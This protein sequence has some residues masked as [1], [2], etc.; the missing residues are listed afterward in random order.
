M[1]HK[2]QIGDIANV[3][4]S[5]VD[6]K[7]VPGQRK[8]KLC[9]YMDAYNNR[10]I[11]GEL[12]FMIATAKADQI[13]KYRLLPDDVIITK[14]SETPEDIAIPTVVTENIDDLICG[15]HLAILRPKKSVNGKF[16]MYRL[17]EDAVRRQ[18]FRVANGSTRYGLTIGAIENVNLDFPEESEQNC[19]VEILEATQEVI[20][21]TQAMMDK[22][23]K[24]KA[25]LLQDLLTRGVDANGKLRNEKQSLNGTLSDVVNLVN[26]KIAIGKNP[27]L[28]YIGLEHLDKRTLHISRHGNALD[29]VSTNNVFSPND[30]LFGKL[31]P[32]LK[33]C[34]LAETHGYCSTDILVLRANTNI[35]PLFSLYI[36]SSEPIFYEAIKSTEG[37]K[38]PRTSWAAIKDVLVYLPDTEEQNLI[39]AV[40]DSHLQKK[41]DTENEL[42]KLKKLKAG[43]MQDLLTGKKRISKNQKEAE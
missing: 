17:C 10:Y 15:Y 8:I 30:I 20:A 13:E 29:S 4:P 22:Q 34:A 25:G 43:L 32:N 1:W 21:A 16:L 28:P 24:I 7:S 31:R 40:M 27:D 39:V 14:D 5:N 6:K 37:T 3:I 19:I 12:D 35:N 18:F 2:K 42:N 36:C 23:D 11:H 26:H 41:R 38:M 33:K 9:N